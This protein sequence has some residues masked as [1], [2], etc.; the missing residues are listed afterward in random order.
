MAWYDVVLPPLVEQPGGLYRP[1]QRRVN[2]AKAAVLAVAGVGVIVFGQL[3][4][5]GCVYLA[6]AG[7][8]GWREWSDWR[9]FG[10]AGRPLVRIDEATAFFAL[11]SRLVHK[12]VEVPLREAKALKVLGDGLRRTLV[13][14]RRHGEPVRFEASW[15][16]HDARVID[17]LQRNLPARVPV[18]IQTLPA[19][20]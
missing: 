17:F 5:M 16:R 13:F 15:G 4:G 10:A 7:W 8:L 12:C 1:G 11:P 14:E 18:T 20:R 3:Y 19:D 9:Q 6:L 2:V